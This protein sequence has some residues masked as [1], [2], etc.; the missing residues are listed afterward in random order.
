MFLFNRQ[1]QLAFCR[2][3][4]TDT[5]KRHQEC[6]RSACVTV[7]EAGANSA[8]VHSCLFRLFF[9]YSKLY[10]KL[11]LPPQKVHIKFIYSHHKPPN[12]KY[13]LNLRSHFLL[14]FLETRVLLCS[15][16]S[17]GTHW[18]SLGWLQMGSSPVLGSQDLQ[19]S[20]ITLARLIILNNE[21]ARK[22][23]D[24]QCTI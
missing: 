11:L 13:L 7:T 3:L 22:H 10:S 17:S 14:L 19:I 18:C 24:T 1:M 2:P 23:V 8:E 9:F 15:L 6:D 20:T 21:T 5:H 16:S 4:Y 12:Q